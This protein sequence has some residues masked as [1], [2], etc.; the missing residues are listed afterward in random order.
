M[1]DSLLDNT[2]YTFNFGNSVVD[3]NESNTLPFL[4]YTISTGPIIDTLYIRG[5]VVDAF[6]KDTKTFISLQLYP[7]DSVYNDSVIY[8]KKPLYVT[9]TL[10]STTYK[11]QNLR[12]GKYNLIA[13][14]DVSGNYFFDQNIDKIG[15]LNRLI[16]LPK[17]SIINLRLFREIENFSWVSPY[18]INDH[19]VALAYF[20]DY[21]NETFSMISEVPKNF[22]FL[23]L[24]IVKRIHSIIGLRAQN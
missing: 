17:D 18:F 10:D 14:Q 7:V 4:T 12:E 2:T 3:F 11:F 5:K 20:G 24:K 13:L 22:N 15:Y 23:L 1:K 9:S 21:E 6:E 19:H 16:E 8:N